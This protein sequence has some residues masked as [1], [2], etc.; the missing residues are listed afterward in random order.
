MMA[1]TFFCLILLCTGTTIA[2]SEVQYI[3]R[4]SQSQ[5]CVDRYSSATCVDND[6]TL[7]QFVNSS[8]YFLTNDTGLIFCSENFSLESELV[9]ENIHSFSMF[10]WP[11]SSS[12]AVITCGHNA[13]FEFRNVSTVTVSG[14]EFVW[15]FENHVASVGQF[16][17]ENSGFFGNDQAIV[18]NG[19]VLTIEESVAS[20]DR[21]AFI[22]T[23]GKITNWCCT[24]STRRL[25]CR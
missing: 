4:P 15:C 17:L 11:S 5:S 3:I 24:S 12:N 6:L 8:S 9:V 10:V 13:R 21:V 7:S 16:Q 22:L 2:A 25:F 1:R 18:I 19:T 20:L 23:I 14:L